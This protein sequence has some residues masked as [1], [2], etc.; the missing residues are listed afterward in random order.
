MSF[1]HRSSLLVVALLLV[2]SAA[3]GLSGPDLAEAAGKWT[4]RTA[5]VAVGTT[6]YTLDVAMSSADARRVTGPVRVS[7][8][9]AG[10]VAMTSHDTGFADH[11]YLIDSTRIPGSG[12]TFT[13]MIPAR[14]NVSAEVGISSVSGGA[15]SGPAT[16]NVPLDIVVAR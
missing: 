7:V 13:V 10:R 8:A 6:N 3:F 11:G 4:Y 12:V 2:A 5:T 1:A 9:A 16:T 14:G 15:I